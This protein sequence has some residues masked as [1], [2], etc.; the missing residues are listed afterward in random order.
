MALDDVPAKEEGIA[1]A[2]LVHPTDAVT[3]ILKLKT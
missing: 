3:L 1:L 2:G